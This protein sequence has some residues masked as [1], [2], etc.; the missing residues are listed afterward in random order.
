MDIETFKSDM[1]NQSWQI[2]DIFDDPTD[3]LD[4][5]F[6][7]YFSILNKHAPLR[8]KRVKRSHQP[9]WYTEEIKESGRIRDKFHKNKE[10]G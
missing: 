4:S 10:Y 3:A 9:D 1:Q 7:F 5:F 6:Q 2:I 8:K